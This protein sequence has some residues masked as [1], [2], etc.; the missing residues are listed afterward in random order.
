MHKNFKLSNETWSPGEKAKVKPSDLS[1]PS[2]YPILSLISPSPPLPIL[3]S[4]PCPF[5]PL[6]VI[7]A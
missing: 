2:V 5:F 4:S 6:K 3:H 1:N 7:S